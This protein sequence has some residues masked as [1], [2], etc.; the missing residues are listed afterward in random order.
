MIAEDASNATVFQGGI[1]DKITLSISEVARR[2]GVSRTRLYEEIAAGR[3]LVKKCGRRTLVP[4]AE[5]AAWVERLEPQT[6]SPIP[7]ARSGAAK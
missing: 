3:L 1:M 2:T 6:P 5:V 7:A 4:T